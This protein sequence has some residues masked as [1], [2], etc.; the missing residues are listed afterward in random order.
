MAQ[1]R[2]YQMEHRVRRSASDSQI[3]YDLYSDVEYV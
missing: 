2:L 3:G 1:V